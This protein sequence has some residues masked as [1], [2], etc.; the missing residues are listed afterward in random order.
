MKSIMTDRGV[1]V[2]TRPWI[3]KKLLELLLLI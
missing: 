2:I 3:Q 1:I